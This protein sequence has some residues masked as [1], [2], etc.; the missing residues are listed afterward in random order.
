MGSF[1]Q[2]GEYL[3][4]IT[5]TVVAT[6]ITQEL[7]N[8]YHLFQLPP[9]TISCSHEHSAWAGTVSI[10]ATTLYSLAGDIYSSVANSGLTSLIILNSHGGN[11]VLGTVIQEGSAQGKRMA[12]FP[13][14]ADWA[15]AWPPWSTASQPCWRSCGATADLTA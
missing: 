10:S 8:T 13:P 1:E 3:P 6:V 15:A 5:D 11:Y 9:L 2:H 7:A 12:L 4:L 14:S